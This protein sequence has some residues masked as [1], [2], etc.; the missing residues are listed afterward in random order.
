AEQ[1]KQRELS[2]ETSHKYTEEGSK[3]SEV[4]GAPV[5][6]PAVPAAPL[7]LLQPNE[8]FTVKLAPNT[9]W[10]TAADLGTGPAGDLRRRLRARF[11]A[12]IVRLD[13]NGD[14]R[15]DL[16]LIGA[17]VEKGRV[18]DLLLRN[19]GGGVFTDTTT[20]AGLAGA[21]TS[22]GGAAADFDNDGHTDL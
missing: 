15:P 8:N 9:R 10:A 17:V 16:F 6:K 2:H 22:L 20:A 14:G 19:D 13:Y 7:P 1:L 3:Y 5:P 18:R 21:R 11:G 12:T 4:I